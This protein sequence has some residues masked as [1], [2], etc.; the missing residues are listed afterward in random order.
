MPAATNTQQHKHVT[1]TAD[2]LTEA[3]STACDGN[4]PREEPEAW[5]SSRQTDAYA[6]LCMKAASPYALLTQ[7]AHM[8]GTYSS[9][10]TLST[11]TTCCAASCLVQLIAVQ[12]VVQ[13]ASLLT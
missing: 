8:L 5:G 10:S 1:F 12:Q 7:M 4:V 3:T 6:L 9:A 11:S 13:F 2:R